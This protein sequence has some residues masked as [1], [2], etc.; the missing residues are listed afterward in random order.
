[1]W[2]RLSWVPNEATTI[3]RTNGSPSLNVVVLKKP[4]ANTV[5]VTS[6]IVGSLD[7]LEGLPPDI[8][9]LVLQND[10]PEVE[11]QLSSLLREGLLGFLFAISA[12]FIFLINTRPTLLRGMTMTLR[13]TAI[14]GVSIPLSVLTGVLV[15]GF[16]DLSL[17]FMSL[18]GLAIAVGRVVD[19]SI[20]VLENMYRHMQR[21][22]DRF[23]A[24]IDGTREVGAAIVSSTLTTVAVFI[25]L[26][27]IQGL[28]GEFFT[29]FAMAVSFALL[30]STLV[31]LTAVPV[32]G[33]LLLREGDFPEEAGDSEGA[34]DTLLQR[35]YTP[36]L[37]WSLRH[38]LLTLGGA[39][40]IVAASLL[41]LFVIPVTFFP[42]GTPQFLTIDVELP[43]GTSVG[44][45]FAEVAKVERVL[46]QFH[47]AGY[48]EVYQVSLG[49]SANEFG[50][51]AEGGG[52]HIAGFFVKVADEGV[53][54][55]IAD[56]I[57]A[58]IP[59]T[60][61]V[62]ITVT[63]IAGG[64]PSDALENYGGRQ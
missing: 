62:T 34:R 60:D 19:D 52:P 20:V 55:D 5:D 45:T 42:A 13:P 61:D 37:I 29:P 15:M 1:M 9:I 39:I 63:E 21:G 47:Q 31:A 44:R 30:A 12:V 33:I 59:S 38:K 11:E 57:R 3:S 50:P 53:P 54:P 7:A 64:P 32:L 18:S 22:E 58:Q 35:I 43:T 27:F 10:G 41:L 48:A 56:R 14:I 16:S 51:G 17:N 36:A 25:P 49:S 8:E 26:A 28:V 24:A 6:Q 23:Q 4:D 46:E 40:G 2:P